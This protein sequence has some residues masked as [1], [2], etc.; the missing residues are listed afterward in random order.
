MRAAPDPLRWTAAG[1]RL[2]EEWVAAAEHRADAAGAATRADRLALASALVK[3]ARLTPA[4]LPQAEPICTLLGGGDIAA[5][6]RCLV[7]DSPASSAG[8]RRLATAVSMAAA[9]ATCAIAYAPL[10]SA[11]HRASEI[12]VHVLP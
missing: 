12:L 9:I 11:V 8:S 3:I 4:A 7:D 6:V 10:V 5:R 1:R 2:E